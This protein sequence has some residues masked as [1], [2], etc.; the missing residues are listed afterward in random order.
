[1]GLDPFSAGFDLINTAL[2]KFFPDANEELKGK[3][4]QASAEIENQFKLTLS[5]IEVNKVEAANP[6]VFVAGWRPFIGWVGGFGLGYEL[7]FKPIV[8]GILLIFGIPIG[9]PGI[10]IGLLETVVGGILGLGL[11]RSWDKA[12]NTDTKVL[13]NKK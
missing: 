2:N 8:N 10:D 13:G 4:A 5:Q 12:K 9:F 1:M 3:L 11:A 7:V 6:S